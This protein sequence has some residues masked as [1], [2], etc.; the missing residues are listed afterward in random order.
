MFK[1]DF[2]SAEAAEEE[3]PVAL[4]NA[5]KSLSL[6]EEDDLPARHNVARKIQPGDGVG[7]SLL[8][9]VRFTAVELSSASS[10][11]G[12]RYRLPTHQHDPSFLS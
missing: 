10:C 8:Y 3:E 5:T 6:T 1:F 12:F 2:Y 9:A 11:S 4:A 7:E